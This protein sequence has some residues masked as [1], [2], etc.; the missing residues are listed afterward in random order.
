M[1]SVGRIVP[2]SADSAMRGRDR[3]V[4]RQCSVVVR[5]RGKIQTVA[6]PD[7]ILDRMGNLG[8][9]TQEL[10]GIFTAL[11]DAQMRDLSSQEFVR[12]MGLGWNLGNTLEATGG[13]LDSISLSSLLNGHR[14]I[15]SILSPFLRTDWIAP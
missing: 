9:V 12:Q 13:R 10:L 7:P 11:A 3:S 6:G 15:L 2:F 4:F 1:A 5:P 8:T 14:E